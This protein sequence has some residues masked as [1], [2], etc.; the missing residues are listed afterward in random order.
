MSQQDPRQTHLS[1]TKRGERN[2]S[3]YMRADDSSTFVNPLHEGSSQGISPYDFAPDTAIPPPPPGMDAACASPSK[4]IRGYRIALVVLFIL[5][6]ALG[7][8][9]VMQMTR[10]AI[11]TTGSAQHTIARPQTVPTRTVTPGTIKEHTTLTCGMCDE[12]VITTLT[13]IT[14]DTTDHRLIMTATLQNVSG[15]QQIDYFAEFSLQDPFGNAYE[16]TGELNA[17]FFL[18]VGQHVFKTEIFS[19]LPRPGILYTLT[20]RLG[21]VGITYDPLQFTF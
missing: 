16:G 10:Y 6:V 4:R 2:H 17:D 13:S 19:F 9:Q 14:I 15:A 8:L 20:G 5:V 3:Q 21:I 12:P 7:S 1:Y 18:G 11:E